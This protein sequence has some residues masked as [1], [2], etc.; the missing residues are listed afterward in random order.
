MQYCLF[1]VKI[2]TH[3]H[4]HIC[5]GIQYIVK[6][7]SKRMKSLFPLANVLHTTST[8]PYMVLL[9]PLT[10]KG[11][12]LPSCL[13]ITVKLL[14]PVQQFSTKTIFSPSSPNHQETFSNVQR[15]LWLPQLQ[16]VLLTSSVRSPGILLNILPKHRTVYP[17]QRTIWPQMPIVKVEKLCLKQ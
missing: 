14:V 9:L 12:F 1:Y 7:Y 17:Q 6:V 13:T 10:T 16:A 11:L 4:F 15:Y 2:K 5:L 8:Y 3:Q